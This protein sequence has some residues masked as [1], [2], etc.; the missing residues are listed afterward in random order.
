[1]TKV[2]KEM[3]EMIIKF[4]N[5]G[6]TYTAIAD[7]FGLSPSTVIYNVDERYRKRQIKTIR[8]INTKNKEMKNKANKLWRS[9]NKKKFKRIVCIS[10]LKSAL[11]DKL[12]TVDDAIKIIINYIKEEDK[13]EMS[14]LSRRIRKRLRDSHL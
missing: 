14:I 8:E 10:M 12:V 1:M 7:Y 5:E 2:T 11:R 3:K 6:M 4:R 13:D 9:K